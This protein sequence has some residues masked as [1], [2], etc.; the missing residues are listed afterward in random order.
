[1]LAADSAPDSTPP[2]GPSSFR[3]YTPE[4]LKSAPLR[5]SH[6]PSRVLTVRNGPV[7]FQAVLKWLGVG[8]GIGGL[9]LATLFAIGVL[10]DDTRNL[11]TAQRASMN[12]GSQPDPRMHVGRPTAA[13]HTPPVTLAGSP[14][15]TTPAGTDFELPD[16][17]PVLRA[18]QAQ[19]A[20]KRTGKRPIVRA[21]PY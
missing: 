15:V 18:A 5:P 6:R 3:V 1:M 8:M 16:Q 19:T 9:L 11:A 7:A 12:A 13:G 4:E 21:A 14:V 17:A 20:K 10:T 2:A